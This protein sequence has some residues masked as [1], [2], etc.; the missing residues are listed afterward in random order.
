MLRN[1]PFALALI[2]AA[3]LAGL[4]AGEAIAEKADR[5]KPLTV[6][7]DQPGRIDLA[8]QFVV[9]TGNVVVTKG[10]MVIRAVRI[11][12]R[13]SADGFHNAVA[14]GGPGKPATFRQKR[15]GVDE[16]IEGEAARLEYDGRADTIRFVGD[17]AV[18]RLRGS[19]VAD[20][21][22]GQTV[23]YDNTSEV[24]SIVGGAP[25]PSNP[26]G[27]VRAVLTPRQASAASPPASQVTPALTPSPTL[28]DRR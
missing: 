26:T 23:A 12:V 27:R 18:R 21:L 1:A 9:F 13:E 15:D 11:E 10:T 7:S 22:S 5:L 14:V 28:G 20:E 25:S 4:G 19:V 2:V 17:A 6:E 24:F 8:N 16:T 3:G